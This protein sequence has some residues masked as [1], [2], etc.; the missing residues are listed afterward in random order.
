MTA[1]SSTKV[2]PLPNGD[3][4]VTA[5]RPRTRGEAHVERERAELEALGNKVDGRTL[6]RRGRTQTLST[7]VRPE[8]VATLHRIVQAH[9]MTMVEAIEQAVEMLDRHLRGSK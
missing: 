1:A 8:T 7:K 9:N 3:I 4:D 5:L 2:V 6:R